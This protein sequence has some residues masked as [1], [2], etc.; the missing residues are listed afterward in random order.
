MDLLTSVNLSGWEDRPCL[1]TD[2]YLW[3]GPGDGE[4]TELPSERRWRESVALGLCS[5]CRFKAECLT[6]ELRRPISQQ[7][8]VRGG[9]TAGRRQSLIQRQRQVAA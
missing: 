8:G 4:P 3:F 2:L 1:D 7:W 5:Q 9:M 6:E